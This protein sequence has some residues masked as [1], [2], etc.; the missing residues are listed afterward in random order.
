MASRFQER[1]KRFHSFQAKHFQ[2]RST[3]AENRGSRN[4][5][6]GSVAFLIGNVFGSLS[7]SL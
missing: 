4:Q 1:L 6:C 2:E 7:G 5:F 3:S